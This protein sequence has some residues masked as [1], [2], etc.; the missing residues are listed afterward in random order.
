MTRA[1]S[2]NKNVNR[3]PGGSGNALP[4]FLSCVF[5]LTVVAG[6]VTRFIYLGDIPSGLNQDEASIGYDAWALARYGMDRNGYIRPVYPITWGS[7]GGSPLLVYLTALSTLI[8]GRSIWSLRLWPALLGALTI[9]LWALLAR[10]VRYRDT[11]SL[12]SALA[13]AVLTL[14]SPWHLLLSRWA[15][16]ANI[17]P[18]LELLSVVLFVRAA[19]HG[20]GSRR[21]VLYLCS[22]AC[23]A[24][25]I[26]SYGSATIVIPI[27]LVLLAIY[28]RR[29]GRMTRR[30]LTG[31]VVVFVVLLL[32]LIAFFA[33]NM[34]GLPPMRTALFSIPVFTAGRSVFPGLSD[35]PSVIRGNVAYLIRFLS[36][37]AEA[38]E[39]ACNVIPGYGQFYRF[40][41]PLT[42]GGVILSIY[43]LVRSGRDGRA[44]IAEANAMALTVVTLAFSLFIECDIN[45][46]TLL[47]IPMLFFQGEAIVWLAGCR[48]AAEESVHGPEPGKRS[49]HR[50]ACY[51]SRAVL[52]VMLVFIAYSAAHM[53]G[54][55]YGERYR[56]LSRESFMPGY[57]EAVRDGMTLA[58]TGSPEDERRIISTYTGL[59][60]P[61]ILALYEAELPPQEFLDTVVWKDA[62]A[63][64]RVATA[65]AGFSFGL[66]EDISGIDL[67]GNVLI[68]HE[69]ELELLGD[70][71][72]LY[73]NAHGEYVV[74]TGR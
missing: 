51:V 70:T 46:L 50:F 27:V 34:L 58:H 73:M 31:S 9:P 42:L 13:P 74:V 19:A 60:A 65:F 37:G 35:L 53:Y 32:P 16:D 36:T 15:L 54:D 22:A 14:V 45:R 25:T 29:H 24:L 47:L 67:T 30:E 48:G 4:A 49:D 55:Y 7:G 5:V 1:T 10:P 64:F 63:E 3:L 26:Y 6:F 20:E 59:A 56:A 44:A 11:A 8:F 62:D 28:T 12:L 52:A 40:T 17:L 68:L 61:F 2:D 33:I 69:S 57:T 38:G 21:M 72:D 43:R 39:L 41:W 23:Y 18:F 66:P 71:G